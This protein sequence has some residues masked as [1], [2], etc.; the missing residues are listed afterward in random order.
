MRLTTAFLILI[1][2]FW[3]S[4][5]WAAPYRR[6]V[7]FEW[8][9]IEG[10]KSYDIELRQV[11]EDP[12]DAKTF[13]FKVKEA[14]W[15]GR[16]T[17]G[18]YLMKLRARDYRGV[19]GD[20]SPES[21]FNVGLEAAVLKSPASRS[22]IASKEED[23]VKLEFQW[24][25]V[26]GAD[27][28]Q[29][30]LTSDDGKTQVSEVLRDTKVKLSLPVANNYTWKVLAA[31][32]EGIRSDATSVSQ[33]SV[34][35]KAL[36]NPKI[37]KPESEFVREVK[38]NRPDNVSSFDVFVLKLNEKDKKWEKFK[39]IENTQEESLPFD[40]TWPGGRYQVA[41]RAKSNLRP[42]SPL[43][44]QSFSVRHG[45]RSPAAEYTALVR[46]SID[47]VT[48]WYAIASYLVTEMQFSGKN[49]E[50]NSA[51][52]YSAL[53][54]TGRMGLGWFGDRTPWGFLGI[55]DMSGFTFNGKTQTFASAEANA[56]YRKTLGD[57]G[58]LRFQVGPYYKELPETVGDPFSGSS[59]DLKI[60]SAGPHFGAE[61]WF[62]L[63]PKLGIQVNAHM[64]MSLLKISTPNGAPLTPSMSTQY[65]FLGSYRFT[66]TFT[67]LVGYARREDKMSYKA[68]PAS[69]NFAVDGDTNESTIVGNYLNIFAEW[70]F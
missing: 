22:R 56:V 12:K 19:P 28:Y 29:F 62:S 37:T 41:V 20:W 14:A 52:A 51:V 6:L 18:K 1:F 13:T 66:P 25:P 32:N 63:T 58:E 43:A 11:K 54:G 64:Y 5:V 24:N 53:G 9:A 38:W 3:T 60:T 30:V 50:K 21:D 35:G 27:M 68:V 39:V 36:E 46:K 34:L 16:L 7:N 42:S 40:E 57:R 2:T 15:N 44:K 4:A 47:R 49:P 17:P 23:N 69:D 10:A 65:G 33:F 26:G 59:E 67:G 8:D 48:G 31:T 55:V 70:A 45:D 61:Y